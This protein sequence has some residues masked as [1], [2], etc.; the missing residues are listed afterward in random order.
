MKNRTLRTATLIVAAGV[1]MATG[2]QAAE[3]PRA[4]AKTISAETPKKFPIP[5]WHPDARWEVS[6][7]PFAGNTFVPGELDGPRREVMWLTGV[8]PSLLGG[9]TQGERDVHLTY[10]ERTERYHQ[11]TRGARGSLDGPFSRAR[12][13]SG[14]Y[15]E[16]LYWVF[17]P[18]G[19]FFYFLEDVY[20]GRVRGLDFA[21]QYVHTVPIKG[22]ARAVTCGDSGKVYAVLNSPATEVLV[23]SSGPEWKLLET[24]KLQ[25]KQALEA[26]GSAL[27]VDEKRGRLY[28]TTYRASPW[29]VWYWDL[30]DG[31]YHGVLPNSEK[32]ANKRTMGEA[33]PFAGTVVYNEGTIGWG[34]DDQDKNHL[35]M[36]RVDSDR[37]YRL[38]L[39]D[40]VL[41]V[42]NGKEGRFTDKGMGTG[43]SYMLLPYWFE[44]GSFSGI[45]HHFPGN[46]R[47]LARRIK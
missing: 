39:E 41:R 23:L 37:V 27:A 45:V 5:V 38:D 10:D 6:K 25:G 32:E 28:G 15:H 20:T 4:A 1:L 44:D 36:G 40:K 47:T 3:S 42:F 46:P 14:W 2:G 26:L 29:Y 19:R 7:E 22:T 34:P 16:D 18:N 12:L 30:K 24:V 11:S 9:L 13:K 17:D 21:K 35:Y 43:I 8:R 33:G 31:N